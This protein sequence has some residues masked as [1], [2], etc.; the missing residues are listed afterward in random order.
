[1]RKIIIATV[2]S[3]A[4]CSHK[5]LG[6]APGVQRLQTKHVNW[7]FANWW[8]IHRHCTKGGGYWDNGKL[9]SSGGRARCCTR[10]TPERNRPFTIYVS[11][12]DADCIVHEVCHVDEFLSED[13]NHRKCDGFGLG[14]GKLR[15]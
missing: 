5:S 6:P 1:M 13:P 12:S 15:P 7:V 8:Q 11:R 3:L 9:I 14:R 4:A 2:L 10:Y